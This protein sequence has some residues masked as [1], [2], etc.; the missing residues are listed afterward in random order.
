MF[1]KDTIK[2]IS[3]SRERNSNGYPVDTET[4]TEVFADVKSVT[5]K[6]FYDALRAGVAPTIAF[7]MF[8]WD[9]AGQNYVEHIG[10]RYKV[11]RSYIEGDMVEL[12]C[13]EAKNYDS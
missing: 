7:K 5:R 11:E 12:N 4:A 9:Y 8:T 2:L 3:V 1:F 10:K 6:E 13:S